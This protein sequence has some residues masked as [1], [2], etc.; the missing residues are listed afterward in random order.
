MGQ[1]L[2]SDPMHKAIGVKEQWKALRKALWTIFS[3]VFFALLCFCFFIIVCLRTLPLLQSF[4]MYT[5]RHVNY[6]QSF[7]VAKSIMQAT[8]VRH[9]KSSL[10]HGAP[11]VHH[12]HSKNFPWHADINF[13]P[14]FLLL[15]QQTLL[16][17]RDYL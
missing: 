5:P 15:P 2:N 8:Q 7:I 13:F 4:C 6:K 17:R 1:I 14:V 9:L 16:K 11:A 3:S 10:T 12:D